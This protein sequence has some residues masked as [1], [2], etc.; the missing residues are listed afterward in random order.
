VYAIAGAHTNR[1]AIHHDVGEAN[2][3][4]GQATMTR[5]NGDGALRSTG[6]WRRQK[7]LAKTATCRIWLSATALAMFSGKGVQ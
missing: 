7:V 3:G 1:G 4:M 2:I 6:P 5:S